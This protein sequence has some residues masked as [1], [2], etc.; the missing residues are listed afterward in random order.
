MLSSIRSRKAQRDALSSTAPLLPTE[1]E[2]TTF[3]NAMLKIIGSFLGGLV[4][5]YTIPTYMW[6]DYFVF[7]FSI[8]TGGSVLYMSRVE[9]LESYSFRSLKRFVSQNWRRFLR[10][11]CFLCFGC[12]VLVPRITFFV[13]HFALITQ[14][15]LIR[16]FIQYYDT[17]DLFSDVEDAVYAVIE[18]IKLFFRFQLAVDALGRFL[19]SQS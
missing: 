9:K 4:V 8:F 10:A 16:S 2:E 12:G 6:L 7:A 13:I 19:A 11:F 18:Q 1:P 15:Q 14:H 5:G 17:K 3:R